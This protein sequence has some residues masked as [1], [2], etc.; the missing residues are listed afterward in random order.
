MSAFEER[1]PSKMPELSAEGVQATLEEIVAFGNRFAGTSGEQRCLEYLTSSSALGGAPDL[2][3][4][5]FKYQGYNA[6]PTTCELVD[7]RVSLPCTPLQGTA[8]GIVEA[9]AVYLGAGEPDDVE[10]V[11]QQGISLA[12]KIVV[13]HSFLPFFAGPRLA[14]KGIAGLVN[15]G[16]TPDGVVG[17][18]TARLYPSALEPPWDDRVLPFPGVTVEAQAGRQL[19][20]T[21]SSAEATLKLEHGG[22]HDVKTSAN[23]IATIPGEVAPEESVV[24]AAH[25]DTQFEG[26]GA[27][28]NTS[29]LAVL[30]ELSKRWRDIK[31]PRS[32]VLLASGVEELGLWGSQAYV[33]ARPDARKIVGMVTLDGLGLPLNASHCVYADDGMMEF[34]WDSVARAG[35]TP[36]RKVDAAALLFADYAPF[37]DADIPSCWLFPHPPQHPYYHSVRD[38][39]QFVD[40]TRL[41]EVAHATGY[42]GYRLA[43]A[44][45]PPQAETRA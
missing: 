35:W 42:V 10:H 14:S 16:E 5:E 34:A 45:Q 4:E 37:I 8:S 31:P 33:A 9:P 11:E 39:L 12:G 24:I 28:D 38:T 44:P 1:A 15:I 19:V 18:F 7:A 22:S 13:M 43:Y 20:R 36:E 27:W 26:P 30:I 29:G 17:H 21:I 23:V 25:Y 6:G 40:N 2:V 3:V 32:V 41:M